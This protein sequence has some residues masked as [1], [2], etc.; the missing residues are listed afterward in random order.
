V[1]SRWEI[2][3]DLSMCLA[4]SSGSR[5]LIEAPNKMYGMATRAGIAG[6]VFAVVSLCELRDC[7]VLDVK[8][9][10]RGQSP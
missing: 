7:Y 3:C 8:V 2:Y 10:V 9:F 4:I 6:L 1:G 5:G